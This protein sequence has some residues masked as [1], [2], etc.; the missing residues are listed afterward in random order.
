[1]T[2]KITPQGGGL[3]LTE[4]INATSHYTGFPNRDDTTL[5]FVPG[6]LGATRTLTL[7]GTNWKV[8]VKG[9][10]YTVASTL[11]KQLPDVTGLYWF[12]I[13]IV[14]GAPVLNVDTS[15]T[16]QFGQ[17]LVATVYWNTTIDKGILSDE[18]HW[19]GR[20][21]WNHEYLHETVGARYALGLGATFTDTTFTIAPGE[22]Y[23]EDIEHATTGDSTTCTVLYHNGSAAWEWDTSSTTVYKVVGGGDNNLRFNNG[24]TLSTVSNQKYANYWVFMT[25][26]DIGHFHSI[27]GTAEY[28]TIA[29]ARA[30]TLPSLG[31]LASAE[32]K[33]IW[34]VTYQN[35]G[36]TPNFIEQ[37]D[38]RTSS[39]LPSSA[40][41][42]TDH[43]T[44]TGLADDDHPQYFS[45]ESKSFVISNPTTASDSPIWRVNEGITVTGVHVL[46]VGGTNISGN[47]WVYD[48]NG[49]NGTS[50]DT[51]NIVAIAGT[52][53]DGAATLANSGVTT[54]AYV[55]WV[56]ATMA[57]TPTRVIVSF[58]YRKT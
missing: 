41:I 32:N 55:G 6:A 19:M 28:T 31:G 10:E 50:V 27:I 56:T 13:T 35:N 7:S 26:D 21:K 38:Y 30:A 34:K 23:D 33:I 48:T 11:T 29:L 40:Y 46:C 42:P 47:L 43:G 14:S 2:I 37:T 45:K 44:L 5:S 54:G 53:S 18:R 17:C 25:A 49:A 57:G 24:N 9:V 3:D 51:A 58:D 8:Y 15:V 12:W 16:D 52:S 4:E 1:M 39:S 36:G 22:I 20:D